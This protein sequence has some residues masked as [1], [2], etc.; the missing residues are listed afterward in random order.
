[1]NT[2]KFLGVIFISL[3]TVIVL[4][5]SRIL[6]TKQ[7][8]NPIKIAFVGDVMLGRSLNETIANNGC[9]YIWGNMIKHLQNADLSLINLE[10]TLTRSNKIRPK[11]FNFK[12]HPQNVKCLTDVGI[13]VVNLAN[14]H[15]LDFDIEGLQETLHT[16]DT[17]G[18]LHVGAGMNTTEARKPVIITVHDV[19]IGIIGY[20]DNE[21]DWKAGINEPGINYIHVGDLQAIQQDIHAI[22]DKVDIVI[23][24]IH[25]GPNMREKPSDEF[26]NFAH[27]MIDA[28]IDIIHGHS[29]HILQGVEIYKNKLI[30]YDTGDFI[31][32][33]VVDEH[34]RNDQSCLFL[35]TIDHQKIVS[36]QLIPA[37]INM[38]Q[39]HE[40]YGKSASSIL[41]R[42]KKLSREFGTHVDN[43][44]IILQEHES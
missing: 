3:I 7:N 17:T 15:S 1:M 6:L 16:L 9:S 35:V 30:M 24:T 34:L 28:G 27:A 33:Y 5:K 38:M 8:N 2:I 41:E 18:I 43:D 19:K 13:D 42:I 21:P 31:D 10:T 32:D 39:V 29:A 23:A 37:L 36:V 11:V 44:T 20:S 25:W 4:K 12:S 40:V 26:V 14:N 22:R